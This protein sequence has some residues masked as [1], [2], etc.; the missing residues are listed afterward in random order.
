[1]T[2]TFLDYTDT[3]EQIVIDLVSE[4]FLHVQLTRLGDG[5][6][7]V[8]CSRL[9]HFKLFDKIVHSFLRFSLEFQEVFMKFFCVLCILRSF[10]PIKTNF[11]L[12]DDFLVRNKNVIRCWSV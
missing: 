10:E 3:L 8:C 12:V 6:T 11:N 4:D 2:L 1:M 7:L 5:G 9:T